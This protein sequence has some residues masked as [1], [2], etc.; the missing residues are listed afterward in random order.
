MAKLAG[1]GGQV[2]LVVQVL[3][4]LQ[5]YPLGDPHTKALQGVDLAR[6]I[7]HQANGAD[8]QVVEHRLANRIVALIGGEPQAL[9]GLDGIRAAILQLVG[10]DLVQQTDTTA[11]L[12]QIQQHATPLG[13]DR[14]QGGLQLR[15]AIAAQAEQG[16]ASQAFR[17]QAAQH[18]LAVGYIAEGQG[19]VLLAAGLIAE[20]VHGK[21]GKGCRQ[22]RGGNKDDRHQRAPGKATGREL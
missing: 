5:R 13:S 6:V 15:T 14:A 18:G 8:P 11:F 21:D 1:L 22:L 7:G 3:A 2:Q 9:V 19:N 12:A 16:V 17:M 20:T 10:A 4:H